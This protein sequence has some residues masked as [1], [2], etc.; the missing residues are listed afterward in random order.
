MA[1][2]PKPLEPTIVGLAPNT[3]AAD[4]ADAFK[5]LTADE[6]EPK[7]AVTEGTDPVVEGAA[8]LEEAKG[9]KPGT[10]T[11]EGVLPDP[12]A[13]GTDGKAA[14]DPAV[15]K[16]AAEEPAKLTDAEMLDRFRAIVAE[17]PKPA[18]APAA[19]PPAPQ[20]Q[21]ESKPAISQYTIEQQKLVDDYIK[22]WPDVYTAEQLIRAKEYQAL[23][24]HI[25]AEIGPVFERLQAQTGQMAVQTHME[26]LEAAV[27]DYATVAPKVLDWIGKQPAYLKS[28]YEAV[29]AKGDIGDVV[30]LIGRYRASVGEAAPAPAAKATLTLVPPAPA[31]VAAE[32]AAAKLARGLAPVA[33]K[34]SGVQTDAIQLDDFDGAF[35]AFSNVS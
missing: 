23:V 33:G 2:A 8:A 24:A 4:F 17:P 19:A 20:P 32:A 29:A 21:L 35:K 1:T 31:P 15:A 10:I 9:E 34:R 12:K 5:E 28:A 3:T 16:P 6:G 11:I 30:D 25:F 14:V 22:E 18:P 13:V 27:P 26:R 7:L